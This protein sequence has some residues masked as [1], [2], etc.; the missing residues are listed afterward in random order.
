MFD[1]I[2]R[3]LLIGCGMSIDSIDKL[4][5]AYLCIS[6]AFL[7]SFTVICPAEA[8]NAKYCFREAKRIKDAL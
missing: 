3:K 4:S 1:N 6:W 2:N 7:L 5:H 8:G